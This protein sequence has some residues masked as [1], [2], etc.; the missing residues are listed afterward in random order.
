MTDLDWQQHAA[1]AGLDWWW[2][3]PPSRAIRVCA[4]CPVTTPCLTYAFAQDAAEAEAARSER[5]P[6]ADFGVWGGTGP[7]ARRQ[8][9]AAHRTGGNTWEQALA[10]HLAW[11]DHE[12]DR[13]GRLSAHPWNRTGREAITHG[14]P[15]SYNHCTA[16]PDGRRCQLCLLGKGMHTDRR[17]HGDIEENPAA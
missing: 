6:R 12:A 11:L 13:T 2:D 7:R 4:G 17:R 14:L 3:A 5:R 9:A 16:G 8:G 1:C 10:D 15:G